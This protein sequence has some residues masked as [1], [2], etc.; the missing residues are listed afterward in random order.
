MI[1]LP[2]WM[3]DLQMAARA[4]VPLIPVVPSG[5]ATVDST[6]ITVDSTTVTVDNG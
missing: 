5:G 1:A 3:P 4:S 6:V 2:I